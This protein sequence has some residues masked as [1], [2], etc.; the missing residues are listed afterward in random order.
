MSFYSLALSPRYNV[1]NSDVYVFTFLDLWQDGDD[2][3]NDAEDQVEAD[4]EL[5]QGTAADLGTHRQ[6]GQRSYGG[7]G[8]ISQQFYELIN[9]ILGA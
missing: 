5:G 2:G 7:Q 4:E 1:R 6:W 8:T 3:H 9:E